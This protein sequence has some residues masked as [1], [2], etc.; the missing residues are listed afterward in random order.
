[1]KFPALSA[2]NKPYWRIIKLI[3]AL[4]A[5]FLYF[6]LVFMLMNEHDDLA[7]FFGA[8]LMGIGIFCICLF[9]VRKIIKNH[10]Q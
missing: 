5:I 4:I 2:K 6:E 3:T 7:V 8:W 9:L 1:M 10:S